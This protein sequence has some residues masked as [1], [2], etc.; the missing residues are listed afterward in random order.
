MF[1]TTRKIGEALLVGSGWA[2]RILVLGAQRGRVRL[3]IEAPRGVPIGRE[4]MLPLLKE[5]EPK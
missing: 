4:E 5:R 3:G 1:V 2:T